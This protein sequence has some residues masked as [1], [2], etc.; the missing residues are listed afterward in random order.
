VTSTVTSTVTV[1]VTS[2][3]GIQTEGTVTTAAGGSGGTEEG[4]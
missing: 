3:G 2:D 1:T 4:E